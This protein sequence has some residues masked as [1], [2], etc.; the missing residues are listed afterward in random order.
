MGG[1][2]TYIK[3][4]VPPGGT[5][6]ISVNMVAPTQ[7]GVYQGFWQMVNA[8][9]TAF[10]TTVYV[11]I[12]VVAPTAVPAPTQTPSPSI[13]FTV[14]QTNITAGQCVTFNWNVQ[15]VKAVYFYPQ[16]A[17]MT[18]YG[19]AGQGSSV[20]CPTQTT[21]YNLTVMYNNGASETRSI[22]IYVAQ[23]PVGAPV[24]NLF[25]VTPSRSSRDS[26]STC[27]GMSPAASHAD[28]TH[29][30]WRHPLGQRTRAEHDAGLPTRRRQRHLHVGGDG[31]R[32]AKPG[33]AIRERRCAAHGY[34]ADRRAA[35][36]SAADAGSA[37]GSPAH[38]DPA[39]SGAADR[40]PCT[41][42]R[43]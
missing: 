25:T 26:A 21:T 6:D 12:Q 18:Q 39:H 9:G 22:T 37:Y 43:G 10:G 27:N 1:Q 28:R 16:G 23:A 42:D 5:Y 33:S 29:A 19:V 3:G 14:N 32:R 7:P 8:K 34:P 30:R 40:G 24:I 35:Y 41:T 17:D 11:G 13:S 4:S 36:C 2:P 20:Q 15:N 31:A 38:R